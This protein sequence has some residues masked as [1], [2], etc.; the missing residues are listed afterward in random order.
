MVQY[1]C[2]RGRK[3]GIQSAWSDLLLRR[4]KSHGSF[5]FSITSL[6]QVD[7]IYLF[8]HSFHIV[9]KKL[10]LHDAHL[11]TTSTT[12]HLKTY[13]LSSNYLAFYRT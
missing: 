13:M 6:H 7:G 12:K 1:G 4:V 3:G 9:Q 8:L 10:I 2:V 11:S 5:Y